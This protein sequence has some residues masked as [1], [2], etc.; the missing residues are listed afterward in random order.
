[1]APRFVDCYRHG[2][3]CQGRGALGGVAPLLARLWWP[4]G[5]Q[6]MN[7]TDLHSLDS[8]WGLC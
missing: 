7:I 4:Q 3:A 1:M 5:V 6:S 8:G 2:E